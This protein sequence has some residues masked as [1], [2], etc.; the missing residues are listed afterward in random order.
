MTDPSS[1]VLLVQ[2]FG[3]AAVPAGVDVGRPVFVLTMARCGSTLLRFILDSHPALACPPETTVGHAC[4]GLLRVWNAL[5]PP[6]ERD[7]QPLPEGQASAPDAD[8]MA[9]VRSVIDSR[10]GRYL[11]AQGKRRWCDKS[12]DNIETAGLLGQL[13]PDAQFICLYRHGMDVVGSMIEAAPWGVSGYGLDAHVA[14]SPGNAVAA[15]AHGWVDKT[16]AVM[17]FQAEHPGRCHGIRYEDLV[18]DPEEVASSL[19]TFLGLAHVPGITS[20]CLSAGHESRGLG[21]HK[22]WSTDRISDDSLGRG[23]RVPAHMVPPGILDAVNQTLGR[24]RYRPVDDTWATAAGAIDPRADVVRGEDAAAGPRDGDTNETDAV[25]RKISS[26]LTAIGAGQVQQAASRWPGAS[27]RPLTIA[28]RPARGGHPARQC[29]LT[30]TSAGLTVDAGGADRTP[31]PVFTATPGIWL[32][33][34]E[35]R[36]NLAKEIR[37]RTVHYTDPGFPGRAPAEI[38]PPAEAHLM[39]QLINLAATRSPDRALTPGR[40]P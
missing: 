8:A 18:T 5:N 32:A 2:R 21:D 34:L 40:V 9:W 14:A 25:L 27:S 33:V 35:G 30:F 23:R 6:P 7:S 19:F 31:G 38:I 29:A 20:A 22:I 37:A 15:V 11:A 36:A 3:F 24:L 13:Y 10:Y 26:R 1:A 12:L 39:G 17:D 28:V 4:A 16:N